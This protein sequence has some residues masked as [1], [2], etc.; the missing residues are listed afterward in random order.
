M[1]IRRTKPKSVQRQH[2]EPLQYRSI[3]RFEV[4]GALIDRLTKALYSAPKLFLFKQRTQLIFKNS[5]LCGNKQQCLAY[6]GTIYTSVE[7]HGK[8]PHPIN[9]LR[10]EVRP[11]FKEMLARTEELERESNLVLGYARSLLALT[12]NV[13]DLQ[14]ALPFDLHHVVNNDAALH[15]LRAEALPAEELNQFLEQN[16]PY[17]IQM[18]AR[19]AMN[20][21]D[22][23]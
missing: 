21:I 9:L 7:Y 8:Y 6:N 12:L 23:V 1:T 2:G 15:S 4:R 10:R 14:K 19:M 11:E 5:E 3:T 16:E 20:L 13:G 18:K 17:L 22:A